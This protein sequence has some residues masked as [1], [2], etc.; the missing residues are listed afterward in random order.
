MNNTLE[1]R[2]IKRL[3][4]DENKIKCNFT[5]SPF[6]KRALAAWCKEKKYKESAALEA[7]ILEMVPK[8]FFQK[9][10][11]GYENV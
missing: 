6:V 8:K 9:Y 2:I 7:L 3:G 4:R 10:K 1:R 5:L 11:A